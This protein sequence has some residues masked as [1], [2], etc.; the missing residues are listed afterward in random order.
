MSIETQY[1]SLHTNQNHQKNQQL[2]KRELRVIPLYSSDKHKLDQVLFHRNRLLADIPAFGESSEKC[3]QRIIRNHLYE[4]NATTVAHISISGG[5][6]QAQVVEAAY[7]SKFD[8]RRSFAVRAFDLSY[9]MSLSEQN[10]QSNHGFD[11]TDLALLHA[12]HNK[13]FQ[14]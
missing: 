13:D 7:E 3:A 8:L 4:T 2:Q 11:P 10:E 6:H 1:N 5:E 12:Y 14:R 9:L